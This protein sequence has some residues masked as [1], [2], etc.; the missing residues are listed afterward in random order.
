MRVRFERRP[1]ETYPE[2]GEQVELE[3]ALVLGSVYEVLGIEADTYRI[4]NGNGEP[5]LYDP[6]SFTVVDPTEPD[7]WVTEHGEEGERYSYP[8]EWQ[9]CFFERVWDREPEALAV[10]RQTLVRYF[11]DEAPRFHLEP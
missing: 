7:F 5:A 9:D 2:T 10:L 8:P 3:P 6:E 1:V 11:P 4:I